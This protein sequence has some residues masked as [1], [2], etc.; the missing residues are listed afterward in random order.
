MGLVRRGAPP[1]FGLRRNRDRMESQ[2]VLSALILLL[3]LMALIPVIW[4]ADGLITSAAVALVVALILS[5]ILYA[6]RERE[7]EHLTRVLRWPILFAAVPGI[8]MLAQ[9]VPLPFSAFSHPVWMST[10]NALSEPVAGHISVDLGATL[11]GF[12]T[13]SMAVGIFI[14]AAALAVDRARA[15][16]LLICLVATTSAFAVLL[17]AHSAHLF[18]VE[19]APLS[20]LHSATSLG[21]VVAAAAVIRSI[22]HSQPRR[23]E[24]RT[25]YS[26]VDRSL[27]MS[28]TAFAFCSLVL[29]VSAPISIAFSTGLGILIMLIVVLVRR[30]FLGVLAG[31]ALALAAVATALTI[32]VSG[33]NVGPADPTLRFASDP[34]PAS[35]TVAERM[36]MDNHAGTGAGTY[37]V[38]LPI[39]RSARDDTAP[40]FAPT[41]ASAVKIELGAVALWIFVIF[42]LVLACQL[43]LGA[44]RRG[45]DSFYPSAAAGCVVALIAQS[46]LNASLLL[47]GLMILATCILGVGVT[48]SMSRSA[49]R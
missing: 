1:A 38:L 19:A 35:I 29:I 10:A 47:T 36:M 25:I 8:W 5:L 39:Y 27:V 7:F 21:V 43:F 13:Y 40:N 45:R 18:Q 16:W 3:I 44:L 23:G 26:R 48:Q 42:S 32:A 9:L 41:T 20:A 31:A 15:E 24:P 22:E 12:L 17:A 11:L 46:F 49:G 6:M 28:S 30:L 37:H 14:A 33:V 2:R 34:P 4:F